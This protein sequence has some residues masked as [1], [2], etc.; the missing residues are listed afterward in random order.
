M[1]LTN[2]DLSSF[3]VGCWPA[4]ISNDDGVWFLVEGDKVEF[5]S[6]STSFSNVG[7]SNGKD[8]LSTWSTTDE[9]TEGE[10]SNNVVLDTSL[11]LLVQEWNF[12]AQLVMGLPGIDWV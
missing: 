7:W 10:F 12:E 5:L 9:G 8:D 11:V 1:K 6:W 3:L 2:L 4:V